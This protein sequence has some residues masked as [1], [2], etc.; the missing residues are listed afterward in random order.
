MHFKKDLT[1]CMAFHLVISYLRIYLEEILRDVYKDVC[2]K[3]FTSALLN[4]DRYGKH[5]KY[6]TIKN[7]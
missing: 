3:V 7:N 4:I 2:I 1:I 6:P 5:L